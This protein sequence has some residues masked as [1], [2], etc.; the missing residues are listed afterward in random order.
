M[1]VIRAVDRQSIEQA[2][3]FLKA[4]ELVA[5]PTETVYG[6]G[7]NALDGESVA[8]IFAAKGRPSFNPVIVHVPDQHEALRYVDMDDKA[9]LVASVFWPGPLTMIL[10][11]RKDCPISELCS[12]G[13]P[14]LAIR[15]PAHPVAQELLRFSGLPIAAPSAN[16]SGQVSATTP[17]H[18]ADGLK[19]KV[20]MILAAGP[21]AVG[22]ESTVLDMSGDQPVVLRPGAVTAE[23]IAD[24]LGCPVPYDLGDH[25]KDVKS[26]GQLLK[27][28]AP[29][30]P[31][32]L[33]AVD[34]GDGEALLG[35][36]SLRFMG[37]RSGGHAK[38]LPATSLRNLSEEG[39][40]HQA[41]ANLFRMLRELDRPEHK[42]IAVMNIPEQGL[43]I[44][45]NDRLKRAAAG[46]Q[47]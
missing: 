20:A 43:G 13:L 45:I 40:L 2:S 3:A 47:K 5:L 18:V 19:G 4:G 39:D 21:C 32:R 11:R 22:L 44:A 38:D 9:R 31:V 1:T 37:I 12:A 15:V 33:N 27:H 34:I 8:R 42:A 30:V 46:S 25:G 6:L 29:S 17:Q 14:T 16:I 41:A 28:Y 7:A 10:P 26:P 36:G 35:F 24:V 23:Q